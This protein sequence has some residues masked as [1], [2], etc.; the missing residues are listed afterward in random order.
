M[1]RSLSRKVI[2]DK[3]VV[4]F[5]LVN[6]FREIGAQLPLIYYVNH[7]ELRVFAKEMASLELPYGDQ[8]KT[9][10]KIG[11]MKYKFFF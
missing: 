9:I 2:I 10:E 1:T 4:D 7:V 6:T 11:K 8:W 5:E 3:P